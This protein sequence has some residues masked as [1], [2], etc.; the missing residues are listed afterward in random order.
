MKHLLLLT[1]CLAAPAAMADSLPVHLY[2]NGVLLA[3]TS[4]F[5]AALDA[6]QPGDLITLAAGQTFA[7]TFHLPARP[8]GT[9]WITIESDASASLPEPVGTFRGRSVVME[10]ML[11]PLALL[12]LFGGLLNLPEYLA[13]GWLGEFLMTAGAKVSHGEEMV[14]QGIAALV[15][16]A[17][18]A[19]AHYRYGVH[20]VERLAAAEVGPAGVTAFLFKGWNLDAFYRFLFIRPYE[21]ISRFLWTR[22]DE[23]VI[24]DSLDR[25]ADGL[26]RAG[27]GLGSWTTGRVSR[28][29]TSFAAGLAL[30]LGWLAWGVW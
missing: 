30:I 3:S 10:W 11:I 22:I 25:L 29:I 16:L 7:G 23:G 18:L 14:L 26:G 6:S 8:S 15:A 4:S 27:Q 20:R 5:Q 12:G 17:G 19:V 1:F 2:R 13:K 21:A 28:Y 9:A 24:D